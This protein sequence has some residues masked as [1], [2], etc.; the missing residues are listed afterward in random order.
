MRATATVPFAVHL[1]LNNIQRLKVSHCHV[2]EDFCERAGACHTSAERSS[3]SR[4][5]TQR[6]TA[7]LSGRN[8]YGALMFSSGSGKTHSFTMASTDEEIVRHLTACRQSG[9][10][11]TL[12]H[13]QAMQRLLLQS[14]SDLLP[15]FLPNVLELQNAPLG[16]IRRWLAE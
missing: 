7:F 13:L 10:E 11:G 4:R 6:D 1:K 15:R 12:E 8:S 16:A 2:G 5:Q 9:G 3:T 14:P